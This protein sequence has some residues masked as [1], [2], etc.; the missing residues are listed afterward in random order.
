M[1]CKYKK[2]ISFLGLIAGAFA[3]TSCEVDD[4]CMPSQAP[5]VTVEMRYPGT[6]T[7]LEDTI[8]YKAYLGEDV[9]IGSGDVRGKSSFNLPIQLNENRT[10]KYVLQQGSTY[11]T[12]IEGSDQYIDHIAKVS[13][14]YITYQTDNQYDSKACG[15]GIYFKDVTFELGNNEWIQ[16][17][18][19][20]NTTINNATTTNLYIFAEPRND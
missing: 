13:E 17:I 10:V 18:E 3:L 20:I 6:T 16:D 12:K 9:L 1:N 11:R 19:T 8:F 5:A 2:N 14:L 15:F 4:V 7:E